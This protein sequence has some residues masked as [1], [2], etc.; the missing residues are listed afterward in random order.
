MGDPLLTWAAAWLAGHGGH[1]YVT[2]CGRAC[3]TRPGTPRHVHARWKVKE[4]DESSYVDVLIAEAWWANLF[5]APSAS[6]ISD[7]VTP[8]I[9]GVGWRGFLAAATT[10]GVVMLSTEWFSGDWFG[11]LVLGTV[12]AMAICILI[13]LLPS[14]L[15]LV[16]KL[17]GKIG[18]AS[19]GFLNF[20]VLWVGDV[21]VYQQNP[22]NTFEARKKIR[23]DLDWL[24]ARTE[25]TVIAAHSL[26][27]LLSIDVLSEIEESK[28]KFLATFGCP[29]KLL[30]MRESHYLKQL[31]NVDNRTGW[32]NFFDPLD[33]IGGPVDHQKAFPYNIK[34]DNSRSVLGAHGGY[35]DNAEQFQD[36]LYRMIIF[37]EKRD[38]KTLDGNFEAKVSG[39]RQASS[40]TSKEAVDSSTGDAATDKEDDAKLKSAFHARWWRSFDGTAFM[41]FSL[42]AALAGAYLLYRNGWAQTVADLMH[43][44]MFIPNWV[45]DFISAS[46]NNHDERQRVA[47]TLLICLATTAPLAIFLLWIGHLVLMQYEA[48]AERSVAD[49]KDPWS[50][51]FRLCVVAIWL[52]WCLP[53]PLAV[54][55]YWFDIFHIL[56]LLGAPV[57]VMVVIVGWICW[58]RRFRHLEMKPG[59]IAREGAE[60]MVAEALG[61]P[62]DEINYS[63]I[64]EP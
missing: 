19:V 34:V 53:I 36:A 30:K 31:K 45:Q 50:T 26:G 15:L 21:M 11:S 17:P 18:D 64:K 2:G 41:A 28:V 51:G 24:T 61:A 38:A 7:W 46:V 54:V 1:G 16:G 63:C 55:L 9:W 42:P 35:P 14:A 23:H 5:D 58:V 60:K 20:L 13:A 44:Q 12:L 47:G 8:L 62:F 43:G 40:A 48:S 37:H 3:R 57:L 56:T 22:R 39:A 33:F 6:K 25:T 49:K 4:E 29:I 10:I 52:V 32:V 27:S 59:S